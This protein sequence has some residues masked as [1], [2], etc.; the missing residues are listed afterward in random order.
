MY[1]KN[2][3]KDF[4]GW[5]KPKRRSAE[6][7]RKVIGVQL[8]YLKRDLGYIGGCLMADIDVSEDEGGLIETLGKV[9][10]QQ[11]HLYQ[12]CTS[13]VPMR[14]VSLSQSWARP[15]VRD[16]ARTNTEFGAKVHAKTA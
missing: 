7:I 6:T 2:A 16:K 15:I 11:L 4:L 10:E 12:M 1:R 14:I 13:S 3:R 8:R 5:S 9:Y